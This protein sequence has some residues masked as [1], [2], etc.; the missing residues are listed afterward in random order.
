MEK[1]ET[2]EQAVEKINQLNQELASAK[3]EIE[4]LKSQKEDAVNAAQEAIDKYNELKPQQEE[5]FELEIKG[6]KFKV[7]FG[8]DFQ[9]KYYS[10]ADLVENKAVV[11]KLV[12]IGSGAITKL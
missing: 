10:K 4:T 3:S 12:K 2:L 7:E 5:S 6:S 8:V 9:G 1:P 11:E